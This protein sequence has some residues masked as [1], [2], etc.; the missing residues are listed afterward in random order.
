MRL[1]LE[2]CSTMVDHLVMVSSLCP[3]A[4]RR[5]MKTA[6]ARRIGTRSG[7]SDTF[8][9]NEAFEL[10][11]RGIRPCVDVLVKVEGLLISFTAKLPT[12]FSLVGH[13]SDVKEVGSFFGEFISKLYVIM[14]AV[15]SIEEREK[16]FFG[17]EPNYENV[18][19]LALL[20][21]E[22]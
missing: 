10:M 16:F 5:L 4:T 11:F 6:K 3:L 9:D 21:L 14:E 22:K 18:I 20:F 15:G 2:L 13:E 17:F 19:N 7:V 8:T 12:L 1:F